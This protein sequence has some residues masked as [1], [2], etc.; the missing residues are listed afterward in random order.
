MLADGYPADFEKHGKPSDEGSVLGAL[1]TKAFKQSK[2]HSMLELQEVGDP[3]TA[4]QHNRVSGLRTVGP[5]VC[6]NVSSC[7]SDPVMLCPCPNSLG[8]LEPREICPRIKGHS[9]PEHPK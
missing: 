1:L 4:R 6:H 8:T 2:P 3:C 5:T 7:P 9:F